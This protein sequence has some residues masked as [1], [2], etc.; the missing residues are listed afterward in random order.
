MTFLKCVCASTLNLLNSKCFVLLK[1]NSLA[2][3]WQ[4]FT[5][6]VPVGNGHFRTIKRLL[7]AIKSWLR[8][9]R[10]PAIYGWQFCR[11]WKSRGLMCWASLTAEEYGCACRCRSLGSFTLW[12]SV[13]AVFSF[14]LLSI[15]G[16]QARCNSL[17]HV[18]HHYTWASA[19]TD[20]HSLPA[21][22]CCSDTLNCDKLTL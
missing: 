7:V 9:N 20:G 12:S 17:A 4:S 21:M 6:F 1:I 8:F 15:K 22:T 11:H 2:N 19:T 14:S 16:E 10:R 5:T 18:H 3:N 13:R